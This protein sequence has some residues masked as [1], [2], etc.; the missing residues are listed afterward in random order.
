MER[1]IALRADLKSYLSLLRL[2]R[3]WRPDLVV[4]GTPKAGLLVLAA[5]ATVGVPGRVFS[6]LGL[7]SATLHGPKRAMVRAAERASARLATDVLCNSYSLRDEAVT[8]RIIAPERTCVV[9]AGSCTGIDLERFRPRS[10]RSEAAR[11]LR[12]NLGCSDEDLL[13]GFVGRLNRDKGLPELAEAWAL[14]RDDHT[15]LALIGPDE[16]DPE[17]AGALRRLEA[18]PTVGFTG[19]L[20]DMPTVYE[21]LDLMVLPTLREGLGNVLIEAAATGTAVVT[22]AVTGTTDV[23]IDGETGTLVP[24]YDPTALAEAMRT[25]LRDPEL[26]AAHGKEGRR[27]TERLFDSKLVLRGQAEYFD[28]ILRRHME[29]GLHPSRLD[30]ELER[31][32]DRVH[33]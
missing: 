24:P 25:Y 23:V 15:R 33:S 12:R 10:P 26:R 2:L 4:A 11:E 32:P 6:L 7:R 29:D 22:T 27:R 31:A 20:D 3:C 5:A 17:C 1:E 8:E 30:P 16:H 14:V 13:V 28:S 19:L 21:A 18:D 9:G